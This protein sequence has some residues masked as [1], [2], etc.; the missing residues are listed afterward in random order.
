MHVVGRLALLFVLISAGWA[1][2]AEP[3]ARLD[4]ARMAALVTDQIA[5]V[6]KGRLKE[7]QRSL[8]RK[9]AAQKTPLDRADLLEAFGVELFATAAS[10][11]QPAAT[12]AA[13]DYLARA[14]LAYRLLLGNDHPELA[15]ALVRK[16]EVERWV[17]PQAPD[18]STDV[19]YETA[20]RIRA[21]KLGT[22]AVTTLSTLIPM[23][24]LKALPSRA[25]GD[26]EKIEAAAGLL[27][28][29][30]DGTRGSTDPAALALNA[31]ATQAL[32]ALAA[33]HGAARISGRRLDILIPEVAEACGAVSPD[34]VMV[35]SGEASALRVIRDTFA[36]ARLTLRPC[37]A[38]L[39]FPFIPGAD[40]SPVLDL[41]SDISAGRMPGVRMNLIEGSK[42]SGR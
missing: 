30:L 38:L 2:S 31:D 1:A 18:L 17:R 16:A 26:P 23:A 28:Q 5:L 24:Q 3:P 7:A 37:G 41:L 36:K 33:E 13:R 21:T 20:Y 14:V 11:G 25:N 19:A 15:T 39:L 27:R 32:Q 4:A 42:A 34:D 6:R 29:V 40:P 12:D 9:I 35:F 8:D 22:T 10:L